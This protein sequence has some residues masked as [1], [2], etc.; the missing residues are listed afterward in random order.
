M[1]ILKLNTFVYL[2]IIYKLY[3]SNLNLRTLI[4]FKK[5]L[6]CFV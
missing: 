3:D 1:R 4:S 6:K 5:K 2:C